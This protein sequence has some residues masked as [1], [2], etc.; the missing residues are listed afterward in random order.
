MTSVALETTDIEMKIP[1]TKDFITTPEF[2]RLTKINFNVRMKEAT[3]SLEIIIQVDAKLDEAFK[4]HK[5][6]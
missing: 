5:I 4:Y 1:N 6:I 3:K 2:N